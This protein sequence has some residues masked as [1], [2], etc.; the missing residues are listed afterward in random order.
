[1]LNHISIGVA[2]IGRSKAFYDA[3][4]KPLVFECMSVGETSLGYSARSVRFWI[5]SAKRPVKPDLSSGLHFCFNASSRS[6]VDSFDYKALP[7]GGRDNGKPGPRPD[8]GDDCGL[9]YRP[10][11]PPP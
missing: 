8:Y 2:D 6:A 9:R 4:L 5:G 3:A 1:M 11:W 10:R 7:R